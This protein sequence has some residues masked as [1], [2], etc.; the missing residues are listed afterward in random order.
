MNA[1][2]FQVLVEHS[3]EAML[4]LDADGVVQYASPATL[5]VFGYAPEEARDQRVIQWVQPDDAPGFA[6]LLDVCRQQ[7]GGIVRVSGFYRHRISQDLLYGEGRLINHLDDPEIAGVLFY[8]QELPAEGKARL[9]ICFSPAT[10]R[11]CTTPA[12][13]PARDARR[14]TGAGSRRCRVQ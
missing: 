12:S 6:A 11:A 9:S 14:R 8:F 5:T 13:C 1:K 3:P 7:S 4:L 10:T 2:G